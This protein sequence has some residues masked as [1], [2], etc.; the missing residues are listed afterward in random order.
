VLIRYR[1]RVRR[2]SRPIA[3]DVAAADPEPTA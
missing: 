3:E 1:V 2:R